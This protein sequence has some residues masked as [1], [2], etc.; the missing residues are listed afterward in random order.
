[1]PRAKT[2]APEPETGEA[3]AAEE[4]PEPSVQVFQ[5]YGA[6]TYPEARDAAGRI[7]GTVAPGDVRVLTTPPDEHW[8]PATQAEAGEWIETADDESLAVLGF[9]KAPGGGQMKTGLEK[10]DGTVPP[11]NL[12]GDGGST[13][14]NAP[15]E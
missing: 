2:T 7:V 4:I 13:P 9:H 3:A 8:R 1:M 15:A 11:V 5:N 14:A 12:T 10:P 6:L